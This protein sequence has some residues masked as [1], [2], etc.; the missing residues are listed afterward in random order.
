MRAKGEAVHLEAEIEVIADAA[1]GTLSWPDEAAVEAQVDDFACDVPVVD[2]E[3]DGAVARVTRRLA[4][5]VWAVHRCFHRLGCRVTLDDA[6]A[7]T[8]EGPPYTSAGLR[9]EPG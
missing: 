6:R 7:R 1:H 3:V 8:R 5:F 9:E 4:G 2:A